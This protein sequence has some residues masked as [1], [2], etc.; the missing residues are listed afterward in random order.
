[1]DLFSLDPWLDSVI[2][3]QSLTKSPSSPLVLGHLTINRF[4]PIYNLNFLGVDYLYLIS[5][6]GTTG[7]SGHVEW[8]NRRFGRAQWRRDSPNS[9]V[10]TIEFVVGR[11]C[12]E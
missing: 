6:N 10:R 5:K 8:I 3:R 1:M 9:N 2:G 4:L 12:V 11:L 7:L